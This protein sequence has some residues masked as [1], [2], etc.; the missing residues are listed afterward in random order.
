MFE[1]LKFYCALNN[2]Q[3]SETLSSPEGWSGGAKVLVKLSVP[4]RPTTWIIVGQGPF[5]LAI[6]AGGVVWMFFFFSRLSF[7]FSLPLSERRPDID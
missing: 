1:P 4:G 2:K 7:L 5:A 6:G 3:I